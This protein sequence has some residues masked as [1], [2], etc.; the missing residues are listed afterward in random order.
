VLTA[1][2]LI[3]LFE[4]IVDVNAIAPY[5]KPMRESFKIAMNIAGE[6]TFSAVS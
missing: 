3:D 4:N 6:T 5:C 2:D 1:L